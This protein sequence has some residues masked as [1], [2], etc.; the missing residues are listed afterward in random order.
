MKLAAAVLFLLAHTV[1]ADVP[2]AERNALV[3]LYNAAGVREP[4]WYF[5]AIAHPSAQGSGWSSTWDLTQPVCSWYGVTCEGGRVTELCVSNVS[6][7][8]CLPRAVT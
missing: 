8:S 5:Y 6:R 2:A 1:R 3:D 7:A 4:L